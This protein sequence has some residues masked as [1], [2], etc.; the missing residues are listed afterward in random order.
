MSKL[1]Q[2][3]NVPE[4]VHRTL[5]ARAA[6]AGMT[7]SDYVLKALSDLATRPTLDEVLE[8]LEARGRLGEPFDSAAAVRDEREARR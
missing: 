8:R 3:K 6:L 2:V 4:D 1:I 5:K 7:L